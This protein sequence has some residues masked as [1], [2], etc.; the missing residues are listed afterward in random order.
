MKEN[1]FSPIFS[2]TSTVPARQ[3]TPKE[4]QD[5]L[6][7]LEKNAHAGEDS[8]GKTIGLPTDFTSI[9]DA[10]RSALNESLELAPPEI[11]TRMPVLKHAQAGAKSQAAN[12]RKK[13]TSAEIKAEVRELFAEMRINY[14]DKTIANIHAMLAAQYGVKQRSI[15]RYLQPD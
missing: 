13:K 10:T 4:K 9:D 12:D 14:P 6:V 8:A 15:R 3:L 7:E 2:T 1:E 11:V 5:A